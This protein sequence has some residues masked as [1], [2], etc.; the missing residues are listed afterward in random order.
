VT[1]C[2]GLAA[3]GAVTGSAG[4]YSAWVCDRVRVAGAVGYARGV[5]QVITMTARVTGISGTY[6][7]AGIG[8]LSLPTGWAMARASCAGT[9]TNSTV[10]ASSRVYL[11]YAV[12]LTD[13][14]NGSTIHVTSNINYIWDSG[15]L[16]CG[17]PGTSS[18]AS[19]KLSGSFNTSNFIG[20][21]FSYAFV[22]SHT[23]QFEFV[24]GCTAEASISSYYAGTTAKAVCDTSRS[25][26][27]VFGL[28]SISLY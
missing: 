26:S 21:P 1:R 7:Y 12:W 25:T 23:Y 4:S 24:L 11:F 14:Y 6:T 20:G 5:D 16:A 8:N 2:A 3:F 22:S 27:P 17:S 28:Q 9:G 13:T 15:Y 18:W 10:G 19:P